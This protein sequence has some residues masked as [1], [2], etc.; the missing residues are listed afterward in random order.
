MTEIFVENA[1]RW[2][3]EGWAGSL[4][5]REKNAASFI[6][7]NFDLDPEAATKSLAPVIN[8]FESLS[9]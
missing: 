4:C 3:T 6:G 7:I 2:A 8:F 9:S 1:E 5:V